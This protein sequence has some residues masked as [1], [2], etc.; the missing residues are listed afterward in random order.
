M[1]PHIISS[2]YHS[3]RALQSERVGKLTEALGTS[4]SAETEKSKLRANY[5]AGFT[6]WFARNT[7]SGSYFALTSAR[8]S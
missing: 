5:T 4:N 8:R 2:K 1:S 7:F 3:N 6:F